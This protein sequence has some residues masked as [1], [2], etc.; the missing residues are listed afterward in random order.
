MNGLRGGLG[1]VSC[2][3]DALEL[4]FWR[5]S[6]C[7]GAFGIDLRGII[8]QKPGEEFE[9]TMLSKVKG[10]VCKDVRGPLHLITCSAALLTST[11][12]ACVRVVTLF[13][14]AAGA[15]SWPLVVPFLE[16]LQ[17]RPVHNSALDEMPS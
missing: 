3:R 14:D 16:V 10:S 4:E 15:Q 11:F 8:C 12:P 6:C 13:V 5:N 9:E 2:E 7:C 1:G 17:V